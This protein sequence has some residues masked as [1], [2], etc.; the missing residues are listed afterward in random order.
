MNHPIQ[1][2]YRERLFFRSCLE[3]APIS[4]MPRKFSVRSSIGGN[5]KPH[6]QLHQLKQKLLHAV[7]EEAGDP[8]LFKH[9]CGAA[10]QAAELAWTTA[11][12]LLVFPCLFEEMIQNIQSNFSFAA[13]QCPAVESS[14]LGDIY[15][16]FEGVRLDSQLSNPI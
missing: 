13:S 14:A 16:A 8:K 15:P 6:P 12:P 7:L 4:A 1:I 11:C 3:S 2:H 9:F 10:N 5:E